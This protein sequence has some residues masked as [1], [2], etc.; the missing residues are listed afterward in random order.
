MYYI[1]PIVILAVLITSLGVK[2]EIKKKIVFLWILF[3]AFIYSITVYLLRLFMPDLSM[4]VLGL[5]GFV[6][7]IIITVAVMLICFFRDPERIP[8]EKERAVISPAD[9]EIVY[10]K[11]IN[12]GEF[13]F[14]VKNK[15]YIPLKELTKEDFILSGGYQIGIGMNFLNV[16]VNRAPIGGQIVKLKRIPGRFYSLK[17][18]S[19]LLKNERVCTIINGDKIQ[20][21][22]IQIASRLVRRIVPFIREGEAVKLGQRIGMI[23]FG[24]QV[25]ILIP[26]GKEV[27]MLV[28]VN[29]EVKAGISV[30]AEY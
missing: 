17:N 3:I 27:K 14:S 5:I 15:N 1:L 25:D 11:K 18:I 28:K 7:S 22:I 9:G 13:P 4:I 2:W 12:K 6:Q 26:N 30:I 23:K 29:D 19:S 20:I 8:P 16:H 21:A 24:S 10:V